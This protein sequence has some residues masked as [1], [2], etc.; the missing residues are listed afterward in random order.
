MFR[1]LEGLT[2]S[3]KTKVSLETY[4]VRGQKNRLPAFFSI[5]FPLS[6]ANK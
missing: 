4:L 3:L 2:Y 1:I 5:F 6:V